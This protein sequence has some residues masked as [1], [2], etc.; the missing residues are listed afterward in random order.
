M[1]DKLA[2]IQ[3]IETQISDVKATLAQLKSDRDRILEQAQHEE[4]EQ[5]EQHLADAQLKLTDIAN[6]ADEA[7]QEITQAIDEAIKGLQTRV[8]NLLNR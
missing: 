6:A 4:I 1:S 3:R 5:L 2:Y 7:W 8:Q